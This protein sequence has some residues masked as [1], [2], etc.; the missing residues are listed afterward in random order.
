[1]PFAERL[2]LNIRRRAHF[3]C[4]VCRSVGIEIHHIVPQEESGPDTADNAAPLCPSCHELYGANPAKRMFIREAR[5]FWYEICASTNKSEGISISDL[6]AAVEPLAT[7][8]DL[9]DL[10][11][12]FAALLQR[13][14]LTAAPTSQDP[15]VPVPLE[16]V[17]RGLYEKDYGECETLFELLFDSRAWYE[18]GADSTD[19]LDRRALFL[20]AYGE[21]TARRLCLSTMESAGFNPE[22]FTEE[23]F[24]KVLRLL[25]VTVIFI[26]QHRKFVRGRDAFLCSIR[27]DGEVMWNIDPESREKPKKARKAKARA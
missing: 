5:D 4:C 21:E 1:M 2:K 8:S 11:G 18:H 27:A 13:K 10:R 25:Q 20:K 9:L 15:F 17:I 6:N 24:A 26:T 12:Q 19:L 14:E 23:D 7:K 3:R 16:R 22:R